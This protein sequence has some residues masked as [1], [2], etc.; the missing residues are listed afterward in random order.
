MAALNH[1]LHN[2]TAGNN[3]QHGKEDSLTRRDLWLI[4]CMLSG[5]QYPLELC[6]KAVPP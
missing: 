4:Q 6:D 3:L 1:Q 5:E 2:G